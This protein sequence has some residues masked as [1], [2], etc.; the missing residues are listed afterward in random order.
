MKKR[1]KSSLVEALRQEAAAIMDHAGSF[2]IREVCTRLRELLRDAATR[3]HELESENLSLSQK[4]LSAEEDLSTLEK[5]I[6]GSETFLPLEGR[7]E[8]SSGE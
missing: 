1:F 7:S 3:L 2:L 4:L 8:P 6:Q 5:Y